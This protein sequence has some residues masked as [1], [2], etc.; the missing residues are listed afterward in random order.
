[1]RSKK[2]VILTFLMTIILFCCT[3][4]QSFAKENSKTIVINMNRTNLEYMDDIKSLKNELDKRGYVGL[5]N[6]RG[7]G[8]SDE[9]KAYAAMGAG[10][11][12]NISSSKE[13]EEF[14]E[15]S[16]KKD[17]KSYKTTTN[18]EALHINNVGINKIING[19]SEKG[20]YGAVLGSLG[21][22]LAD[23]KLS[24]SVLGN[25]DTGF[26]KKDFNRS[27]LFMAM[28]EKGR[29]PSG[30]IDNIN[31]SDSSMPFG[32]RADYSKL[33]EDTSKFY[34]NS[35]VLFVDL[36]DTSRLEN[37]KEY[38]TEESFS[39][40]RKSIYKNIDEYLSFVFDL[41]NEN[42]NVYI[43]SAYPSNID[44]KNKRRLV[45]VIK[46]TDNNKGILTSASTRRNGILSNVDIAVDILNNYGLKS[47][48][49]V[50][51]KFTHIEKD[52]NLSFLRSEYKR[53]VAVTTTRTQAV[54]SFVSIVAMS[55]VASI[56]LLFY[57]EKIPKNKKK[58]IFKVLKEFIKLGM[59]M[60]L[61]FLLAPI[62]K[63]STPTG[64]I[65]SITAMVVIL[66]VIGH[67][68][69][70]DNDMLQM[71]T[72]AL[73]TITLIV[74]DSLNGT[75]LMQNNIMSYDALIGA[76]YYGIGN[77]YEGVTIAAAVFSLSVFAYYTNAPKWIHAVYMLIILVTSAYPSMGANVGGAISETI[78]YLIFLA[79]LFDIKLDLKKII[80]IILCMCLVVGGF[81]VLDII[82][83]SESHLALFVNQI[84]ENG[85]TAIIQTFGRKISMNLKLIR[86][87]IWAN[88]LLI[89]VFLF[90]FNI[91]KPNKYFKKVKD[92]YPMIYKGFCASAVGCVTTLL[93]ND[94]GVV[95]AATAS[96]YILI[97]IIVGLI[98]ITIFEEDDNESNS[99][100]ELKNPFK[101]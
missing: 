29:I 15:V 77:E 21:Q 1:M 16:S 43:V 3:N 49:M 30:N 45:P 83:G 20:Q 12:A 94:S 78:A 24:V 56:V 58:I 38:L 59:I 69:F 50:G 60:P 41:V 26:E 61:A 47:A 76:R 96:I 5:M 11:K 62:T 9:K 10:V 52:D 84:F 89:A 35:D 46:F 55:W 90:V 66:E 7:D 97:P 51:K 33:K 28:D 27:F 100:L 8:G 67:L 71:G 32:L 101:V 25:S 81:A 74:L 39:K 86:T 63:A 18:E 93:V 72:Y 92:K 57:R 17:A 53:I 79:M 14:V 54:N 73:I 68:S 70:K 22:T 88:L 85:P 99:N 95:A 48:N 13:I 40:M 36:G 65:L 64:I 34:E 4:V 98:N 37:Y 80:A 87:S 2:N 31:T 44:N 19:N 82:T 91:F 6:M 23:N 75:Y 42:D